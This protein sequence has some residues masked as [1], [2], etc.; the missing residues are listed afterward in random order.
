MKTIL[1]IAYRGMIRLYPASFRSEFGD[2]MLWIFD[3]E[4]SRGNARALF[5][6]AARSLVVRRLRTP[7]E[8][9]APS[10]YYVEIE[11][12]L[13]AQRIAQAMMAIFYFGLGLGLIVLPEVLWILDASRGIHGADHGWLLS[14]I[15]NMAAS[16]HAWWPKR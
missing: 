5:M 10:G 14:H 16:L 1:R 12:A 15:G 3:E 4:L 13:P 8:Q 7:S 11:S 2:E 9:F 6:D